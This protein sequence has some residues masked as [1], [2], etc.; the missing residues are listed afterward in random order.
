M[1]FL[2]EAT[3]LSCVILFIT[4]VGMKALRDFYAKCTHG[5]VLRAILDYV[6]L[7]LEEGTVRFGNA[8][9]QSCNWE[10]VL[11]ETGAEGL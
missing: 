7:A 11:E 5:S 3:S 1:L 6:L 4:N 9:V 8:P 10:R 2:K